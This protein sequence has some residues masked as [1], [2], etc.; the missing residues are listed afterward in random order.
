MKKVI[1]VLLAVFCFGVANGLATEET[2]F[3]GD[4]DWPNVN[5]M[6]LGLSMPYVL[7]HEEYYYGHRAQLADP[8]L[9]S[10]QDVAVSSDYDVAWSLGEVELCGVQCEMIYSFSDNIFTDATVTARFDSKEAARNWCD[11]M[12]EQFCTAYGKGRESAFL[13][14]FEEIYDVTW[15]KRSSALPFQIRLNSGA[16][17]TSE[18]VWPLARVYCQTDEEGNYLARAYVSMPYYYGNNDLYIMDNTSSEVG[19]TESGLNHSFI[20][21]I[22]TLDEETRAL[23]FENRYHDSRYFHE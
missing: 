12:K 7:L 20:S 14:E 21:E 19:E 16:Y 11:S 17:F 6:Q 22:K 10:I 2:V 23:L 5:G 13:N 15:Q 1:A 3:G 8:T 4:L 18:Y 9:N